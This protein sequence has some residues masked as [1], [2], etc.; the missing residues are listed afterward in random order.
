[1]SVRRNQPLLMIIR[2]EVKDGA[3]SLTCLIDCSKLNRCFYLLGAANFLSHFVA[4]IF[5]WV[6]Q[7][8]DSDFSSLREAAF[9]NLELPGF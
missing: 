8:S 2:G 3:A 1:M 4:L 6:H 9:F 5:A 7:S